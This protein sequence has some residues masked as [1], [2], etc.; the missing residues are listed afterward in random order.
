MDISHNEPG[1]EPLG[2]YGDDG[3]NYLAISGQEIVS[4]TIS[5]RQGRTHMEPRPLKV[6]TYRIKRAMLSRR[7]EWRWRVRH[8]SNGEIMASGQGY[9]NRSDMYDAINVMW[10]DLD[11]DAV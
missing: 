3:T 11:Q 1:D 9:A 2:L 7:T 5:A 10:P 4:G 6:E 8:T